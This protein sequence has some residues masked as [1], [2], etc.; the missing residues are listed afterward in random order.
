MGNELIMSI[1]S[2]E[3]IAVLVGLVSIIV[4]VVVTVYTIREGI[5]T[6]RKP[7]ELFVTEAVDVATAALMLQLKDWDMLAATKEELARKAAET[8]VL[9]YQAGAVEL[10]G[11]G[12][13]RSGKQARTVEVEGQDGS[14]VELGV[15]PT[16][17]DSINAFLGHARNVH[18]KRVVVVH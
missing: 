10:D 15:D 17:V 14:R 3:L 7:N 13:V 2:L 12:V 8:M 5:T 16:N 18:A 1:Y 4:G 11:T 9:L 6:R